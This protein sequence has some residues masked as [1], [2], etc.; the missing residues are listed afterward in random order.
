MINKTGSADIILVQ[1]MQQF[2]TG[3]PQYSGI[4]IM[5]EYAT[6]HKSC[7]KV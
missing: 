7:Y 2:L 4:T 6:N 5:F 1:F 3:N